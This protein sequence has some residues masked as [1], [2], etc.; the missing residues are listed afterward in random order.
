MRIRYTETALRELDE[1][2]AYISDRNMTAATAVRARFEGVTGQLSQFPYMAQETSQPGV[3]RLPL[4]N[5]PYVI[6]YTV[7]GNEVVILRIRHAA[8]RPLWNAP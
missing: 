2:L 8:R 7:E 4:G 5:F 1:I 3:R 6:F